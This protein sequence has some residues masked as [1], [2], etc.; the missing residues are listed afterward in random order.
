[1]KKKRVF[2]K[3]HSHVALAIVAFFCSLSVTT[4]AQRI[5]FKRNDTTFTAIP[6][7]LELPVSVYKVHE[8]P[9]QKRK[10]QD[11]INDLNTRD[12]GQKDPKDGIGLNTYTEYNRPANEPYSWAS[13]DV[14]PRFPG[15]EKAFG[16]FLHK[17]I[18]TT[19]QTNHGRVIVS[20]IVETNGSLTDIKVVRSLN[21]IADK[22]AIRILKKSPKW[23]PGIYKQ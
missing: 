17:N 8:L 21:P 5:T 14:L 18:D 12:P 23:N 22:E 20:F 13:V 11:T 19:S 15:G 3:Y 4:V 6:D 1:M 16:E 2:A 10:K 9:A 7:T